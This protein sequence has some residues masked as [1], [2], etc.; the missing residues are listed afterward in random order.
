[1]SQLPLPGGSWMRH[2]ARLFANALKPIAWVVVRYRAVV[3]VTWP[4]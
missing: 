2:I 4:T 3:N 1:M